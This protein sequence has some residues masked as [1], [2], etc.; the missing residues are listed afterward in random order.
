M[1]EFLDEVCELISQFAIEPSQL[2]LEVTESALLDNVGEA[3]STF[4]R[5]AQLGVRVAVDDF[6][7]GYSN[8]SYLHALRIDRIKIDQSFIKELFTTT[9]G[10][11]TGQSIVSAVIAMA[12]A[13]TLDIVAEGVETWAQA[14]WLV[15]HG[16][17]AG[18]GYRFSH[19]L[20]PEEFE[21]WM[22]SYPAGLSLSVT[23][24][25]SNA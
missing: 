19:P 22:I 15:S 13:M 20:A 25:S 7:T 23:E 4:E 11:S 21:K 16:C 12:K 3:R 14:Q 8:L 5:L 1:L 2:E 24:C 18:Q 9:T 17:V 10:Q 6:G